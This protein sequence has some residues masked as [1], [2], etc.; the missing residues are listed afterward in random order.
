MAEF[1]DKPLVSPSHNQSRFIE[2]T[3]LSV[4]NQ[5]YPNIESSCRVLA[6]REWPRSL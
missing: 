6:M 3:I 5:N 1:S 2:E 4:K